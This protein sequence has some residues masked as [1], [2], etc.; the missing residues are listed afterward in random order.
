MLEALGRVSYPGYA[1]DVVSLGIIEAVEPLESAGGFTVIVRQVS[2]SDRVMHDLAG[3]ISA[4]LKRDLGVARVEL[5]LRKIEAEL[6]EKTG[7]VRLEGTR[8]VVAVLS[9]KGGV[10]KSTVAVN[11]AMALKQLGMTVGLMDA[12]VYGPSVPMMFG[13]EEERP[14][15]AGGQ[16]FYPVER[17]GVKLISM[18]F[19]LTD[20]SPVI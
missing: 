3:A 2:E 19:F 13:V 10:G 8:Y 18:G 16:N 1:T 12:D 6:G 17:Y 20:K 9:G 4:T 15:G 7:R 5:K 14:R 11:L